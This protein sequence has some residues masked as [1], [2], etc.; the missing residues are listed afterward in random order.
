MSKLP[1]RSRK[2]S[3]K[4]K[5]QAS[6]QKEKEKKKRKTRTRRRKINVEEYVKSIVK[7]VAM[8]L[9]LDYLGLSDEELQEVLGP[10]LE[11]LVGDVSYK[12]KVEQLVK[13]VQRY[14]DNIAELISMN[15]LRVR[16]KLT[17][18]QLEYVVAYGRRAVAANIQRLYEEAKRLNR[19]D[20]I[21][22][23]RYL[24]EEYGRPTPIPCPRCGFRAVTPDLTCF[25]CGAV[26]SEKEIREAVDFDVVFREFLET[27]TIEELRETLER[28]Y[29]LLGETVK[30]PTA[31]REPWDIE[32]FL[33][34]KEKEL[35]KKKIYEKT[36][37]K[38]IV[39]SGS[40]EK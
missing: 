25:V 11:M 2:T 15:L 28:G 38:T 39:A 33:N 26:L 34:K 35:L 40:G 37:A 19:T 9:G 31:R 20:L 10:I 4:E 18:E 23:L 12:P 1:R 7:D 36:L 6:T 5:E 24:W 16:E 27:A 22:Q 13:R 3:K 14:Y 21:P 29:V 17:V 30:P 8:G 32:L